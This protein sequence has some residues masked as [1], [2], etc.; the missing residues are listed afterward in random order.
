MY[1]IYVYFMATMS[2]VDSD[3]RPETCDSPRM[4]YLHMSLLMYN[5]FTAGYI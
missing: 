4:K 5:M 1:W 2:V 3:K